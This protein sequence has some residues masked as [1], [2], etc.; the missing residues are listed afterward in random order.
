MVQRDCQNNCGT[1]EGL[2][3]VSRTEHVESI[4]HEREIKQNKTD[5]SCQLY[6]S[7]FYISRRKKKSE[8]L[9]FLETVE[10]LPLLRKQNVI[11]SDVLHYSGLIFSPQEFSEKKVFKKF[12]KFTE[13]LTG[14]A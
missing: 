9:E 5:A 2:V 8:I 14:V 12:K 13:L 11:H 4:F 7:H 1:T 6:L 3:T 10:I